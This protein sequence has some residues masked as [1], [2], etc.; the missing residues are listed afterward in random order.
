ML[1]PVYERGKNECKR[2]VVFLNDSL[3]IYR[4]LGL[5]VFQLDKKVQSLVGL[6]RDK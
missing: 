5:L 1:T 4:Y 6:S 3:K 2:M